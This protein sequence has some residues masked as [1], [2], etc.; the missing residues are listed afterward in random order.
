M[1]EAQYRH[2]VS[3]TRAPILRQHGTKWHAE[4]SR[5]P[6]TYRSTG[7]RLLVGIVFW[8]LVPA[9]VAQGA[10]LRLGTA[11]VEITPPVGYPLQGYEARKQ[12]STRVHDPLFAR[13][14][15]LKSP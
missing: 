1:I 9:C 13:V 8:L 2:Q 15:V 5:M 4:M 11:R 10:G 3:Q 12:G 14:L 6:G 7:W